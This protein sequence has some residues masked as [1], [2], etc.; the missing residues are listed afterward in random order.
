MAGLMLQ[1][2]KK[3]LRHGLDRMKCRDT[4]ISQHSRKESGRVDLRE[5]FLGVPTSKRPQSNNAQY[6]R[7]PSQVL[8]GASNE[9]VVK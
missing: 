7:M 3:K 4:Q 5:A 2:E 1:K 9:E 6:P 8:K